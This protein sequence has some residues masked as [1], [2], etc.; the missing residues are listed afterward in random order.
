MSSGI[1][2]TIKKVV[3][4]AFESN[5]PVKILFGEVT[6]TDPVTIKVGDNLTLTKEFLVIN[7]TVAKG[8][9][10]ALI[11]C[12]GGQKYVVLGT[13]TM[14]IEN[15]TYI[16]SGDSV[17]II[18]KAVA[19]A[20]QIAN[21]DS[22]KYVLG[23]W[24][25]HYDCASFV[26]TAYENAGV[27]VKSKGGATYCPN[28]KNAFLKCGFKDVT[29]SVNLSNGQGMLKG[30]VLLNES[31][32]TA[33]VRA[34]G[35]SIV[36]ASNPSLGIC[37]RSYY[38]KP[39]N[40]V[41]RYAGSEVG[42]GKYKNI[43]IYLSPSNQFGNNYAYGFTNE[44]EQCQKIAN[45]AGELLKGYGFSVKVGSNRSS[46]SDRITESNNFGATVHIP[47]HT[48]AG[49]GDGAVVFC[50]ASETN[51]AYVKS[52]YNNLCKLVNNTDDGIRARFDLAEINRIK[53]TVVYCECEFHDSIK[54]AKFIVENTDKIAKAIADG[55]VSAAP[56]I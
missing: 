17:S 32:H 13:R 37:E 1:I 52:I 20:I 10:I 11:R 22:H 15:T 53:A 56:N 4:G 33:L 25:P 38:N 9:K 21:D 35:G 31:A 36:H 5:N 3:L 49:G 28:M 41:L 2:D 12:Q 44:A 55:V 27:P 54:G 45:K 19:W 43:K 51:N 8:D 14:T 48:N 26:I 39:W 30:D 46:M 24:G 34:D 18:D 42:S 23:G 7:G 6:S 29:S 16:P 47:I 50:R 40:C